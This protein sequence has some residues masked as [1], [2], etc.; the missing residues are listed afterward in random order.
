MPEEFGFMWPADLA[1]E[2]VA[3]RVKE[4]NSTVIN[5]ELD[6]W[7]RIDKMLAGRKLAEDAQK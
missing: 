2:K 1:D 5:A 4:R 7:K 3:D 6:R